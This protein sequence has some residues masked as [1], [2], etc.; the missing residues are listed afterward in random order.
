MKLA[1]LAK[2]E[3][4][5]YEDEKQQLIIEKN[6][7]EEI[8][9]SEFLLKKEVEKGLKKVAEKFGDARR[10]QILNIEKEDDEPIENKKLIISI[11]NH[12]N[13]FISETSS[14]YIQ[15]RGGVGHKFKLDKDE[16]ILSTINAETADEILF[17]TNKGNFYHYLAGSIPIDEKCSIETLFNIHS[18]ENIKAMTNLNKNNLKQNIIFITKQGYVKK[19][20]LEE[21]NIK[22]NTGLKAIELMS[23]DEIINVLFIDVEKIGILTAYG[24]FLICDTKD[25]KPIKRVARGVHGIK[26]ASSDYVV[27]SRIIPD[28]YSKILSITQNGFSKITNKTE[29][30]VGSRYTKG[31]KLQKL[32]DNED[33]LVDFL[34]ISNEND[35]IIISNKSQI[36]ILL[37]SIPLLSKNTQGVSTIKLKNKEKV[38]GIFNS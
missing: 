34:T 25:I 38:I 2:L 31:T 13:I 23:D 27:S 17:F 28:T 32:K 3:A 16:Y 26:L 8:L 4:K 1:R 14:L 22:R 11:T 24:Q 30:N 29:I 36:K 20:L 18:Y 7:I 9:D 19:S 10:T 6:K 33:L 21:Y 5:K 12:N 37:N 35:I 15:K